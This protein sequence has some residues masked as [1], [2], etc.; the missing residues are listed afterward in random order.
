MKSGADRQARLPGRGRIAS[1]AALAMT[2]AGCV[3]GWVRDGSTPDQAREDHA[4]CSMPAAYHYPPNVIH[5]HSLNAAQPA[6]DEDADGLLRDEN[7]NYCLR[8]KG[9]AYATLR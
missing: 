5:A 4:E 7:A 8:Q 2:L 1:S 3:S 9:Y 6:L